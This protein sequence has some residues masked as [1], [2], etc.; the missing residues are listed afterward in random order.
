M[1]AFPPIPRSRSIRMRTELVQRACANGDM[2]CVVV[3]ARPGLGELNIGGD[4]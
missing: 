4:N 3:A 1:K 2:V